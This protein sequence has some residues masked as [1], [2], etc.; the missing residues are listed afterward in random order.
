MELL[1]TRLDRIKREGSPYDTKRSRR[2]LVCD[3]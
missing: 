1:S 2:S 3:F